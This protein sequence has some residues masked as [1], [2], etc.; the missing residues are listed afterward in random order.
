MSKH[1]SKYIIVGAGLSGLTLARELQ[2]NG[3]NDFIILES[4]AHIGGRILTENSIDLGATW[5]QNHHTHIS[6]LMNELNINSFKQFNAGQSVLVYNSMAPPHYFESDQSGPAANRIENGSEALINA[7]AK[8]IQDKIILNTKVEHIEDVGS[9]LQINMPNELFTCEKLILTLPPKLVNTISF[10]PELPEKLT[11]ILNK[12]HT[13]MSNAIKV[14][15][16]FKKAFWREKG[17]SGTVI[18]QISEV[19]ELY[20][21][22][23]SSQ[24]EFSLMG[25]VNE[26]LRELTVADRKERILSYLEKHLGKDIRQHTNYLEKDWSK[27]QNTSCNNLNSVYLSPSYG[28]KAFQE[29]YMNGKLLLSGTETSMISGGYMDGAVYSGLQA[30]ELVLEKPMIL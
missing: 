3:E 23:N 28:N 25:F 4:R 29:F 19:T 15:I 9:T 1:H 5:F 24:T 13:W 14:G 6:N 30:A 17:W 26:G 21:H 11:Q 22:C 10:S 16:T 12:T 7:L 18:S 27:D 8:S 20:D 2:L